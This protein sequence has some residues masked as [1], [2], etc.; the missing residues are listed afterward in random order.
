MKKKQLNKSLIISHVPQHQ[1]SKLIRRRGRLI[2]ILSQWSRLRERRL[3]QLTH[4]IPLACLGIKS[5]S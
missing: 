3:F 4:L 2:Q 1:P 5:W